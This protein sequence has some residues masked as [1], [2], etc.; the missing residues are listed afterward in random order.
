MVVVFIVME[1]EKGLRV[2][3]SSLKYDTDDKEYGV[4]DSP[5]QPDNTPLP[6]EVNRFGRNEATR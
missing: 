2:Y 4:F 6:E 1:T 5:H 3:L